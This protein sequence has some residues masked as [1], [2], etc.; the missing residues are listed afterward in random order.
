MKERLLALLACPACAG[1]LSLGVWQAS[2]EEIADGLLRCQ[3]GEAFPIIGGVPRM[4]LG[5]LREQLYAD[6]A[7]FFAANS[8]RLPPSL[9]RAKTSHATVVNKTQRSFGF[10]WTRFSAM[11][12]EWE[13]NFWDYM[14]PHGRGFF[15]EKTILDAGCGM[16]RH[17]YY[18]S[19]YG[20]DVVGIDFSRAVDVAYRNTRDLPA[21]HVVQADLF[22]LPFHKQTFDFV[23]CLGVLHH[24]PS[25]DDAL[26]G[27]LRHLKPEGEIRIYVYWDLE[28][29][30]RWK[31]MLLGLVT[32]ARCVTTRLPHRLLA[33]LCYPIAAAA[34]LSFVAPYRGLSRFRCTKGIADQLPLRQYTRYPFAVLLNDQ[35]DRFSAPLERRYSHA[36][37]ASWLKRAELEDISVAA[38]WGWLGHGRK[39]AHG[40]ARRTPG[41]RPSPAAGREHLVRPY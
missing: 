17:L 4:L 37:V 38:N 28:G 6:Y 3:C 14:T 21:A 30:P 32:L 27:L 16:G 29:A 5:S 7:P 20:K 9:R 22:R 35:F 10:E 13:E 33:S 24:V 18:A 23:Y 39:P 36:E 34:W 2:A 31:R 12:P 41:N 1:K 8:R 15:A 26:C 11:L 25:P 40:R 19:Q